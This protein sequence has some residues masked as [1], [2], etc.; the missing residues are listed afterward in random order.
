[1]S[2]ERYMGRQENISM[3]YRLGEEVFLCFFLRIHRN[4]INT[5]K[6]GTAAARK[7]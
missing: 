7:M 4:M 5:R 3:L 2:R 6:A 1:L